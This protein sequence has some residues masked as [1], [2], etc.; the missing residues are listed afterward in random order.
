[1]TGLFATSPAISPPLDTSVGAPGPHDSPSPQALRQRRIRVHRIPPRVRDDRDTP[2][3]VGSNRD[4][5][6]STR[7]SANSGFS[8]MTGAPDFRRVTQGRSVKWRPATKD[9]CQP[10]WILL[11]AQACSRDRRLGGAFCAV[12]MSS[13]RERIASAAPRTARKRHA[14]HRGTIYRS[15]RTHNRRPR[16]REFLAIARIS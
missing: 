3:W 2:S 11:L 9:I 10:I 1:V 12:G 13:G 7:P 16:A 15:A 8:E 5:P 6:V 4:T 14:F